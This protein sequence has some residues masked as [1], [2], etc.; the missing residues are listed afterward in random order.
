M[1]KQTDN[2]K[3][4]LGGQS[5]LV[6]QTPSRK[7]NPVDSSPPPE[8]VHGTYGK[9]RHTSPSRN[10]FHHSPSPGG[11]PQSRSLSTHMVTRTQPSS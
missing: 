4:E 9:E 11:L 1:T 10:E 3:K 2:Q 8:S 6:K 7:C 5:P